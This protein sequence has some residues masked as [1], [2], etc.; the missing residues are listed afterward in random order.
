VPAA[1]AAGLS[2]LAALAGSAFPARRAGRINVVEAIGY[3]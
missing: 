1:L 3:E 2:V